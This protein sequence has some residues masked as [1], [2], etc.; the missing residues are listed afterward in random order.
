MG[1][2]LVLLVFCVD[3]DKPMDN[4]FVPNFRN[5]HIAIVIWEISTH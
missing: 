3:L 4:T 1:I 2:G 5:G